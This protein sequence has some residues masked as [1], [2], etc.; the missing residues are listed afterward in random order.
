MVLLLAILAL[1][2]LFAWLLL[3]RGYSRDIRIGGFLVAFAIPLLHLLIWLLTGL[4][5][6]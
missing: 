5:V 4:S 3:R 6:A 2:V 1:P